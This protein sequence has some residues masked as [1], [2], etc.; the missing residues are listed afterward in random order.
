MTSEHALFDA[1][2][3]AAGTALA[4]FQSRLELASMEFG[5]AGQRLFVSAM[6]AI[7]GVLLSAAA[8]VMASVWLVLLMW[9]AYGPSALAMFAGLYLLIGLG[10]LGWVRGRLR[11]QA[12][13]LAS[14]VAEL[15]RDAALLRG[16]SSGGATAER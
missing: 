4:M 9:P 8:V 16:Q 12:P 1:V 14:T 5:E 7:F 6:V 2:R 10:L 13:L 3:R 15:R 11:R